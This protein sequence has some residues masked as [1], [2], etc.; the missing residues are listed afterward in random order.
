[1]SL[2]QSSE[3]GALPKSSERLG[4]GLRFWSQADPIMGS[5]FH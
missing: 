1:M 4:S 5:V 3:Q 2:G